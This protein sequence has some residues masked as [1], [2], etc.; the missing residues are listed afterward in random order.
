MGDL[1]RPSAIEKASLNEPARQK[2]KQNVDCYV[3]GDKFSAHRVSKPS[4]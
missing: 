1:I 2:M 3:I 4:T